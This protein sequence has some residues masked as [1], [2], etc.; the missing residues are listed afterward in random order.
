M[1][2]TRATLLGLLLL[3]TS[4]RAADPP[5]QP[6][7]GGIF[8]RDNLDRLVHRAVR[9]EEAGARGAGGDAPAK[10]GFK[11][12]AYDW[13]GEHVPTFDAEVEALKRHGVALDAFWDAGRAERRFPADPR[14]PRAARDQGP[15]LGPARRRRGA[16]PARRSRPGGS[17]RRRASSGPWPRRPP[18][19]AAPSPS[20]TTAA[21]S[22]SRRTRS[23]SSPELKKLRAT[24]VGMVYNLHHGHEHSARFA[25]LL[26]LI[27]APPRRPEPRTGWTPARPRGRG[28]SSRS[29]RGRWTSAC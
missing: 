15:A 25:E 1:T 8:G 28:R 6:P 18:R 16:R 9:L 26:K 20:T 2:P 4:A 29:G 22:A 10:L 24:N 12:F 3:A 21:G 23:R 14:P 5:L 7:P 13:R 27:D 19:S 17:R 11:H